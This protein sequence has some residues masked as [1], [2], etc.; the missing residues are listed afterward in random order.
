MIQLNIKQL[1]SQYNCPICASSSKII[2]ITKT[3]NK[4]SDLKVNLRECCICKHWWID[5]SPK[6]EILSLLY[7]EGSGFV[8]WPLD[9]KGTSQNDIDSRKIF[10]KLTNLIRNPDFNYLE[11][12]CGTGNLLKFF[13]KNANISYGVEPGN[14]GNN[15]D[16]NIVTGIDFLPK[17]VKFDIIVLGDVLEHISDPNLMMKKINIFA[18]K[19]AIIYL[20]FPNK[21]CLLAKIMKSKWGMVSPFGHIHSFSS[22]SIDYLCKKNSFTIKTKKAI[23][24]GDANI[25]D[26]IKNFNYL[27][28]N[29]FFC[30]VK[31]IVLILLGKDQWNVILIK[32]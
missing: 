28:S 2:D 31:L 19:N 11:I 24:K 26:L 1:I 29:K 23:R 6:Q 9:Y 5:P 10:M 12:G 3:M 25:M 27:S 30:L 22:K 8:I 21:D 32:S 13:S 18:N 4:H 14:W 20:N 7:K 17:D 15:L 16:L